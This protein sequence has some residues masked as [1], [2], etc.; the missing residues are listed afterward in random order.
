MKR[1][2]PSS[3]IGII[4][5][6]I[7]IPIIVVNLVIIFNGFQDN[8]NMPG[9]MGYRPAIVLSGS[10]EPT[11]DAGDVI[12][13]EKAEDTGNLQKGD[14]ITY[15]VSGK[16]TTHRIISVTDHEGKTAYVTKGDYNNV[17]D[18]LAVYPEQI[19]GIYK[20]F[21]IPNLGN[22]LMFMQSTQGMLIC[23]GIPFALY[24]LYDIFKRRKDSRKENEALQDQLKEKERLE[25]ELA[26]LKA[27]KQQIEETE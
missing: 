26:K 8:E 12:V 21:L 22:I 27:E 19:Q 13:I 16:A 3:V 15:L 1:V 25:A 6:I 17:E 20:G 10:M 7:F 4:A 24:I 18:R 2:K 5:C 14:V 9:F 11:F 23:L